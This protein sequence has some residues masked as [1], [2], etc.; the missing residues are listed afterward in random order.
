MT[1]SFSPKT[2][3]SSQ[4]LQAADSVDW[5]ESGAVTDVKDQGEDKSYWAEVVSIQF[6]IIQLAFSNQ[7]A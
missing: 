7:N 3:P 6:F 1:D 5:R 2:T 4:G